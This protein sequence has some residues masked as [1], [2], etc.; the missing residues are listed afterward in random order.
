MELD[1]H[2]VTPLP[3]DSR[4]APRVRTPV[5]ENYVSLLPGTSSRSLASG[6]VLPMTRADDSVD[7]DQLLSVL[8][9]ETRRRARRLIEGIGRRRAGRGGQ[10][11]AFLG[12]T[13]DAL[14]TG[15]QVVRVLAQDRSQIAAARRQPRRCQRAGRWARGRHPHAGKRGADDI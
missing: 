4:I 13:A 10:L 14:A 8:Q 15:S 9:G 12:G 1:D 7:V 5:G 2:R 3:A 6:S 11:N